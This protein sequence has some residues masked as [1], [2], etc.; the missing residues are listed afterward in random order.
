MG[1]RPSDKDIERESRQVEKAH[2]ESYRALAVHAVTRWNGLMERSASR[3]KPDW[4]PMVGVA[5]VA[6]FYFLDA[7]C[8]GCRQ[9]K[10]ID[11]R[12]LDRHERTTLYGLIP[13]LSCQN[14]QPNPPFGPAREALAAQMG[15]PDRAGLHAKA[16]HLSGPVADQSL[17]A[18]S[19]CPASDVAFEAEGVSI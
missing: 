13:L 10:Q 16:R 2:E 18:V 14:C 9:L 7:Y 11:L 4:S 8:P 17:G 6:R 5:I 12:K 1:V 15:E 19:R 3:R